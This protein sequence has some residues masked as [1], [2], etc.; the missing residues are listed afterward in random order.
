MYKSLYF[1]I[2]LIMVVFVIAAMCT[3]GTI[4]LNGIVDYYSDDFY[5]QMDE[6]L[7]KGKQLYVY[8]E[9]ILEKSSSLDGSAVNELSETVSSWFS[10]LG[11]DDH[12]T[13][14]ILSPAGDVLYSSTGSAE[15]EITVS[16]NLLAVISGAPNSAKTDMGVEYIDYAVAV[17]QDVSCIVYV[18][19]TQVE[20]REVNWILF[21]IIVQAVLI[22]FVIAVLLAFVLSKAIAAPI[23]QLDQG[24]K[25]IASGDFSRTL[26]VNSRDEIG[27]LT[28]NFNR[29]STVLK[30]TLDEVQNERGKLQTVF[31]CLK[32]GVIAFAENGKVLNIN[33]S[34]IALFG[35]KYGESFSFR[36]LLDLLVD[37]GAKLPGEEFDTADIDSTEV[38]HN[39]V[40]NDK[41]LEVSFGKINYSDGNSRRE[42]VV[43]VIHDIT[44]RYA[45][46]TAQR[47]FVA[48]VSHELRTPLT[49]IKGACEA[50][51]EH[52]DMPEELQKNFLDMAVSESD[53][54]TRIVQDLLVLS[55]LDNNRTRWQISEYAINDSVRHVC[56]VLHSEAAKHR[57]ALVFDEMPEA[58]SLTADR[59]KIEQV[60]INIIGNSIK[61][62]K[63]G[64][65]IRVS[66]DGDEDHISITV[67]DNGIGI[68]EED[69]E[70]IFER[71]YRVEKSRTAETG[72]TGLGLAI[73]REIALAHGGDITVQSKQGR[74]T[75]VT[76]TLPRAC[77]I[78]LGDNQ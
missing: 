3:V 39:I 14:H 57:H 31:S 64:G 6:N 7:A 2:I 20:V 51:L 1:K 70:H 47:E 53:R 36:T 38:L 33:E 44:E 62:T 41:V 8:L 25:T 59:E 26:E 42:G 9:E 55:R 50:I 46:D 74:G 72:G 24:V 49:S 61:Y 40:F 76:I 27:T 5:Q 43:A 13:V 17:G 21:S 77:K 18:I 73:A 15:E 68:P 60:M 22:A 65:V 52:P 30:N 45:L 58:G 67:R 4:L 56:N 35:D 63:D 71:F 37:V 16:T 48:N 66:A 28:H 19:D 34:A 32:D 11:I 54:M 75:T 12:R 10:K 23:Q 78:D 29:M 69:A